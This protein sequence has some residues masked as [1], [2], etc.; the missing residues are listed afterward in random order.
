MAPHRIRSLALASWSNRGKA[1]VD[2]GVK[3]EKWLKTLIYVSFV[4]NFSLFLSKSWI[5]ILQALL[6]QRSVIGR[7]QRSGN[8]NRERYGQPQ[9][10]VV[11][12]RT[13]SESARY[14]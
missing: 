10:I 3:G 8:Y 11:A 7:R 6:G 12:E 4:D 1:S 5:L 13:E 9:T 14:S 2:A